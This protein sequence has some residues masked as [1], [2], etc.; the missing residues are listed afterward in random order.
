MFLA[1]L[2]GEEKPF[3]NGEMHSFIFGGEGT[4]DYYKVLIILFL[5]KRIGKILA[6]FKINQ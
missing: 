3:W 2:K 4:V 6:I 1:K 5:L